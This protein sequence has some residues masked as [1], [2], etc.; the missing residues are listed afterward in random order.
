M[1]TRGLCI[2]VW[3]W[4]L[5]L[6]RTEGWHLMF[7]Y[8]LWPLQNLACN[9]TL[10]CAF[11]VSCMYTIWELNTQIIVFPVDV[12]YKSTPKCSGQPLLRWGALRIERSLGLIY[13][14]L[15]SSINFFFFFLFVFI[16]KHVISSFWVRLRFSDRPSTSSAEWPEFVNVLYI[17]LFSIF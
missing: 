13:L 12:K 16:L 6:E 17:P 2:V 4:T 3:K 10:F 15:L 14:S 1:T 11:L 9:N 5:T 8:T 7:M